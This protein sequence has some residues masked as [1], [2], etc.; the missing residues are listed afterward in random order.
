MAY[1]SYIPSADYFTPLAQLGQTISGNLQKAQKLETLSQLGEKFGSGD[2][3]G[4]A[5][6]ALQTGDLENAMS[7]YKLGQQFEADK[8]A[9]G[10]ADGQP[11][12]ASAPAD[13][14]TPRGMRNF[15]PGNIEDGPFA[16]SQPGYVGSDGRFAR[17]DTMEHGVGAQGNLLA[18]YG[19]KGVNTV[20]GI[21]GRWAPAENGAATGN[22]T[23]FVA[24]KLGIGPNDP[25]D[26]SN[27][28]VRQRVA[29]AMGEFENGRP[30]QVA[31]ATGAIPA[32]A[33]PQ[34]DGEVGRLMARR[35][36]IMRALQVPNQSDATTKRLELQLKDAEYQITRL[37]KEA[38]RSPVALSEGQILV[39]PRTGRQ[40]AQG[41]QGS[42]IEGEV[43]A[44]QRVIEAQGGDPKEPR[45]AQ[46]IATGKYPR[47]D[48]QPLT[49]TD[50]KAI[51]EADDA[52][53]QNEA[54]IDALKQAKALSKQAFGF[55]GASV[56]GEVGALFGSETGQATVELDNVVKGQA[57][58]SLKSIFGAA[59]TEGE[60][61]ILLEIQ[62]SSSQ[63]DAVRQKIFDR[64]ISM[65][66]RR[67]TFN[68]ERAQSMRGGDYYK[69]KDGAAPKAAP[70]DALAQQGA[71]QSG[72][73]NLQPAPAGLLAEARRIVESGKLSREEVA[74]EMRA[75]G[76]DPSF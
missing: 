55:R 52:V 8:T 51:L 26:L 72:P 15:N 43:A 22:Y 67:L 57:L 59:P 28:A 50:K 65:A 49:A 16:K 30:V 10:I 36:N 5:Q 61:K 60:R 31:D 27:P 6:L 58:A 48:A 21:V 20:S 62:G 46:F 13:A 74:A 40:I 42:K 68:R 1:G 23:N 45:N 38:N 11:Q 18:N 44:R 19:Q 7:L 14:S 34:G 24:K 9:R 53:A 66:E 12:P 56:A 64:A 69:P 39:D 32:S 35:A 63:P 29:S 73:S 4:A 76:F 2:Y 3:K 70:S 37:D 41:R 17:F 33:M 47:E 71:P 25:L 54:A 75:K